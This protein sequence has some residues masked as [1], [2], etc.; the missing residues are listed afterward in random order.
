MAFYSEE[1]I[2][3]VRASNDIIDVISRYV[4]LQRKGNSYFGLCPFHREKTPSF[5]ATPD[6]QI[7]HCFGCG[8]GG[9]VIHFI[10][11]VENINFKEAVEFLAERA[12]IA[13]PVTNYDVGMSQDELK[14]REASK[15]EM[16]EINKI[17]K[18]PY[19]ENDEESIG[20][21]ESILDLCATSFPQCRLRWHYRSR[22][23]QLIS[24]SNKNFYDN[25]LVTFPAAK[26]KT[27]GIGIDYHYVDGIFDRR[28]K[29]NYAEAE[30][31]ADLVFEHIQKYPERSLGVVAFS[32]SQQNL[33]EKLIAGR[34][35]SDPSKEAF[36]KSDRPEPFFVKNLETVQGDERDTIIFSIAYAKDSQGKLLLNFGPINRE[37]G[38]RRLN[39][40]VTRAKY[41]IQLYLFS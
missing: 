11:K 1:V 35:R 4:T 12:N 15:A 38:E 20:D 5:S 23:E 2:E 34:R 18:N 3:E 24:F 29:S 22:F 21:F 30:R 26:T 41:S 17:V 14:K 40:A 32:I 36:F 16:Y 19:K 37:G 33:I 25:D 31:V 39:V 28:S 27:S 13:L 10:M 9:N 7:F 8:L 6:K